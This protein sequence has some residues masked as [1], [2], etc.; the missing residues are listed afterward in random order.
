MSPNATGSCFSMVEIAIN[1]HISRHKKLDAEQAET[2]RFPGCSTSGRCSH[3]L[4]ARTGSWRQEATMERTCFTHT[5]RSLGLSWDPFCPCGSVL[6]RGAR[7][8]YQVDA[9]PRCSD[10]IPHCRSP[11][12]C[13]DGCKPPFIS[14]ITVWACAKRDPTPR[15]CSLCHFIFKS[16]RTP[17]P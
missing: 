13:P 6:D 1:Q 5:Y 12:R 14:I 9:P 11:D 4:H 7:L 10:L 3:M 16:L 17:Q 15:S 2:N 8:P